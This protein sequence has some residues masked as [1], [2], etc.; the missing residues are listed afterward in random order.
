MPGPDT[1]HDHPQSQ[2]VAPA[3]DV[4]DPPLKP[5]PPRAP[6]SVREQESVAGEEDPGAALDPPASEKSAR[7]HR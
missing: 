7:P 5:L 6:R 1:R 4:N 2:P 3:R